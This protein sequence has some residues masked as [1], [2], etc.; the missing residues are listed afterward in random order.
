MEYIKNQRKPRSRI[1]GCMPDSYSLPE[2]MLRIMTGLK[3]AMITDAAACIP[4]VPEKTSTPRP[5]KKDEIN[6][7]QPGISKGRSKIK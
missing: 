1:E 5:I 4:K 7:S 6:S 3:K 2:A